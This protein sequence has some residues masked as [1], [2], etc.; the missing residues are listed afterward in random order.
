M[1]LIVNID[2][3]A[4]PLPKS[5]V[6]PIG[7]ALYDL[8][9]LWAAKQIETTTS[10]PAIDLSYAGTGVH[11]I[12]RLV[13]AMSISEVKKQEDGAWA[14]AQTLFGRDPGELG[15]IDIKFVFEEENQ[16]IVVVRDVAA[17]EFGLYTGTVA[18]APGVE[19]K[20]FEQSPPMNEASYA[21]QTPEVKR[22]VEKIFDQ[23]I[24]D[25][26][27]QAP[28]EVLMTVFAEAINAH[29]GTADADDIFIEQ[30][31][32]YSVRQCS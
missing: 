1:T 15:E 19:P 12:E 13:K 32:A 6:K 31:G 16:M 20:S 14:H 23:V 3:G 26:P 5:D 24:A 9:E 29:F 27:D 8:A 11:E 21:I 2:T 17:L 22:F 7:E 18:S 25:V 4:S 30:L 28:K 10:L